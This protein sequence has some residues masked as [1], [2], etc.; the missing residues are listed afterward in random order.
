MN[1]EVDCFLI[2]KENFP[3]IKEIGLLIFGGI[4]S[5]VALQGLSTWKR[6]LKGK[7]NM[8]SVKEF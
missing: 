1:N 5:Y 3:I 8:N 2:L 7:M 6:Q 4:G